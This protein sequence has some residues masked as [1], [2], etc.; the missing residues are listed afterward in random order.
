LTGIYSH[1]LRY[2]L[3]CFF[4]SSRQSS[5]SR[6]AFSELEVRIAC[7]EVG[8]PGSVAELEEVVDVVATRS[9]LIQGRLYRVVGGCRSAEFHLWP[10]HPHRYRVIEEAQ[11]NTPTAVP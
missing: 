5:D 11:E 1:F 8:L 4:Q 3:C 2:R 6:A 7:P 9:R 10:D